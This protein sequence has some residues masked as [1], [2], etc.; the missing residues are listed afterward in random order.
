M[1]PYA[2]TFRVGTVAVDV[3]PVAI[4]QPADAAP[5]IETM[6]IGDIDWEYSHDGAA[7]FPV[8]VGTVVSFHHRLD[9]AAILVR[10]A[11]PGAIAVDMRML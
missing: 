8:E 4:V 6:A 10:A 5:V 3:T 11:S 7:W 2:S 9:Q 1:L